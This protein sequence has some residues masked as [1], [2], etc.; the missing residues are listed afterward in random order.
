[1]KHFGGASLG[2]GGCATWP[3]LASAAPSWGRFHKPSACALPLLLAACFVVRWRCGLCG[4]G[5]V[6]RR[7]TSPLAYYGNDRLELRSPDRR[8]WLIGRAEPGA[9][10]L[11]AFGAAVASEEDVED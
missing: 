3:A 9:R 11:V 5:A 1:M 7:V 10:G 4:G 2:C 8:G 6:E